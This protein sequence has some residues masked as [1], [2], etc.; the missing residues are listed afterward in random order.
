MSP[1]SCLARRCRSR[2][3]SISRR[4]V[5]PR[6]CTHAENRRPAWGIR[7]VHRLRRGPGPVRLRPRAA[8]GS[9]GS[10]GSAAPGTGPVIP[11]APVGTPPRP[12]AVVSNT[13]SVSVGRL[14]QLDLEPHARLL[15]FAGRP[16]DVV[17]SVV[18][19]R[20]V[21]TRAD[22]PRRLRRQQH[23]Q[24]RGQLFDGPRLLARGRRLPD[25]RDVGG[26][27]RRAGVPESGAGE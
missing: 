23:R 20:G 15:R 17:Q 7:Q 11:K 6:S 21:V 27:H 1:R 12:P 3:A 14:G 4:R 18:R 25:A 5:T 22:L 9:A 19:V 10:G 13:S 24:R 16:R 26:G 8:A 2:P